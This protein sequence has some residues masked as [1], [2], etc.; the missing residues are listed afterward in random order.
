MPDIWKELDENASSIEDLIWRKIS[1]EWIMIIKN[2]I[3]N[4]EQ[5]V[6]VYYNPW[7]GE[8]LS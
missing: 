5:T 2:P 4:K 7:T 1:G 8:E 6:R 3:T